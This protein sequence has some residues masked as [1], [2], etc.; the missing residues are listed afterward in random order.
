MKHN[1]LTPTRNIGAYLDRIEPLAKS[2]R[3]DGQTNSLIIEL[4]NGITLTVPKKFLPK[5]FSLRS[6]DLT[7]VEV[8]APGTNIW[9]AILDEGFHVV[10]LVES[11]VGTEW[12]RYHAA[13]LAG[14]VTS[15]KKAIAS[16]NNGATGGR[17]RKKNAA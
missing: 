3:F 8:H 14:R 6:S 2:A 16:R 13:V 9:F 12:I 11:I 1:D 7:E 4:K 10:D 17:P 15:E 5:P